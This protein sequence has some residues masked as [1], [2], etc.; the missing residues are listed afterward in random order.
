VEIVKALRDKR[1]PVGVVS[2]Q[3][4][5]AKGLIKPGQLAAVNAR[6]EELFGRFGTW[7][8]CVHDNGDGC[9]CRKPAPGMVIEAARE[10]G[11]A[12]Q[13]C[14]VI[15]DTGADVEAAL[16]AGARA[17]LVPTARTRELE[18]AQARRHALVA[19]DLAEAV[20]LA[21]VSL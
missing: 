14:V 6:V 16:A 5:V 11:V 8:V 13:N 12:P 2:N 21:G 3:S 7:Q 1:I 4:G 15:G 10:L 18:I 19:R 9:G 20:R 17:V